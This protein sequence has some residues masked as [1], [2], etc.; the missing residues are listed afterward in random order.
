MKEAKEKYEGKLKKLKKQCEGYDQIVEAFRLVIIEKIEESIK[1]YIGKE[2][3]HTGSWEAAE[4]LGLKS[5]EMEEFVNPTVNL[6]RHI[7]ED[8]DRLW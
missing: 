2:S 7:C 5:S 6:D 3:T 8:L 4:V 1:K